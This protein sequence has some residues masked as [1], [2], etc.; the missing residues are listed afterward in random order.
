MAWMCGVNCAGFSQARNRKQAVKSVSSAPRPAAAAAYCGQQ[1][2][3]LNT[4][5]DCMT[6]TGMPRK[7]GPH[8]ES[9]NNNQRKSL[10]AFHRS[11]QRHSR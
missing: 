8:A 7:F 2:D 5:Y 3:I 4:M 10:K 6:A 1:A 9:T 11:K